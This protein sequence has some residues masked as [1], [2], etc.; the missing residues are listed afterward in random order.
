SRMIVG[1]DQ[2]TIVTVDGGQSWSSW[3]N[4]PTAQVYHIAADYRFPYWLTGAQPDS[5]AVGTPSRLPHSAISMHRWTG[6][7]AGGESGYTAPD[8]LH[9]DILFGGTVEKCNVVTGETKNVTPEKPEPGTTYRHAWTQPLVFSPEDK[10]ALYFGNQFVYKTS[11]GGDTW[12]K[13]SD[14]LTREDPGVPPNLNEAAAADAP[15]GKRRGVVYTI[16]PSPLR[17][18]LI[19]VGT[20]DGLIHVTQDDGKTW[21]NVTPPEMTPW[22]K[23]VMI[24]AS[25]FDPNTA[26]A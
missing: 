11:D 5:G 16:A 12:T 22:T 6:L 14:D 15:A 20:D 2:G 8:P 17:A 9:P 19:W 4:Q 10:H 1:G 23:V 25:H 3:Y 18:P 24:E 7:C 21:Q 26:F 13:I